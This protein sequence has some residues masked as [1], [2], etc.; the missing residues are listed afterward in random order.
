MNKIAIITDSSSDLTAELIGDLPIEIIPLRIIFDNAEYRDRVDIGSKE[1]YDR[2]NTEI[3]KTSLPSPED[4]VNVFEKL[5]SEGYTQVIGMFISSGLSGTFNVVKTIA[6]KYEKYMEIEIID[7]LQVSMGLGYLVLN[8]A[9]LSLT[10]IE[11]ND[12]IKEIK[13]LREKISINFVVGTLEYLKKGGRIGHLSGVVGEILQIK[14]ILTIQD[15]SIETVK[16]VKGRKKSIK[17]LLELSEHTS[18]ENI[19][20]ISILHANAE[21]E[22]SKIKNQLLLDCPD[23]KIEVMYISAVVGVHTGPGLIGIVTC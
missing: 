10:D 15:G 8:A 6:S 20:H 1:I 5:K 9:R 11:I 16:K 14:P 22:A 2:M 18:C 7:S 12:I 19:E 4:I 17:S 21:E 23:V 3:P 13:E